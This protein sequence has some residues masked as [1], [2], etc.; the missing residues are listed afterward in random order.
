MR[1]EWSGR[2]VLTNRKRPYIY[3][4]NCFSLRH[5]EIELWDFNKDISVHPEPYFSLKSEPFDFDIL[6][7]SQNCFLGFCAVRNFVFQ[8]FLFPLAFEDKDVLCLY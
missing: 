8:N 5:V 6:M 3:A 1:R 4:E 7:T 2:S